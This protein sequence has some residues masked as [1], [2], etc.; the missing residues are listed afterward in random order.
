M[1][2]TELGIIDEIDYSKDYGAYEPE[3][4]NC[5]YIDDEY[6]ND[7]WERLRLMKTYFHNMSRPSFA[8]ARSGV[9][10]I[11]PEALPLF[12]DIVATDER[13]NTDNNLLNLAAKIQ[14]AIDTDKHMIHFGV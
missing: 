2:K 14:E 9:T 13:T 6:I 7:W 1:I 12:Q 5:I 3:R 10:I 8:L 11:P 4:Y